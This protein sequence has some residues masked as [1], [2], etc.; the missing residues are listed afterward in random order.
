MDIVLRIASIVSFLGAVHLIA[1]T[2]SVEGSQPLQSAIAGFLSAVFVA[3]VV[4]EAR[5][6]R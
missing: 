5:I 6:V 4:A 3:C 2:Y 1:W